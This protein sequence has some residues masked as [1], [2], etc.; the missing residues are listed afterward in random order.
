MNAYPEKQTSLKL[1]SVNLN[2]VRAVPVY[3]GIFV[4]AFLFSVRPLQHQYSGEILKKNL[5]TPVNSKRFISKMS[6]DND[7]LKISI[8]NSSFLLY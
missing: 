1:L 2:L 4:L 6:T 8:F 3:F 5:K 7:R